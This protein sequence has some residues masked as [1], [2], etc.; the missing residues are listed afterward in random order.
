[1]TRCS[2][3]F[4]YTSAYLKSFIQESYNGQFSR[5]RPKYR[6]FIFIIPLIPRNLRANCG[7]HIKRP[8][9]RITLIIEVRFRQPF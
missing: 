5:Q 1:M 2:N 6:Y 3:F 4:F 9:L 8:K 7:R